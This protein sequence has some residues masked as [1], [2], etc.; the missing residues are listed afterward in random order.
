MPKIAIGDALIHY[1][2]HGHG[3]PV[4]LIAGL[5]SD[6]YTWKKALPELEHRHQVIVFDNRGAGLTETSTDP[7][8]MATLSDDAAGLLAALDIAKAHIVGWSMGGNV[9]QEFALRHPQRVSAL[10][11]MSTY[12]KEPDRSRYALDVLIHAVREGATMDTFMMMMRAWCST[13][14]AFA[15]VQASWSQ[16]PRGNPPIT[17]DGVS[18]QKHALDGF[19]TRGRARDIAF[20]TLVLHGTEDIMVPPQ[21]GQDLA[22]EIPGAELRLVEGAGHFLPAA[23][24]TGPVLDFLAAHPF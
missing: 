9:A 6:L 5:A 10:V 22:S 7:F 3:E 20:P 4:L 23:E 2:V 11:L 13:N 17:I 12:M 19:D 18:R 21:F 1:H 8:T 14:R 24:W 16:Q 15:D